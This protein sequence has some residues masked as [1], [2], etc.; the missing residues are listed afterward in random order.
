MSL[1]DRTPFLSGEQVEL[2]AVEEADLPRLRDLVNTAKI[3][4]PTD[5][6]RPKNLQ[7]E[8]DWFEGVSGD[9]DHINLVIVHDDRVIGTIGIEL[10]DPDSRTAE[11]GYFLDPDVHSQG[12]GTESAELAIEYAF[13][14]LNVRKLWARVFAFNDKSSGLL[15]KLGFEQE[16]C[17]REHK[18]ADGEY[19]DALLYGLLR[20]E[21][22]G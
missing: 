14:E 15:E 7:D 9:E 18:Y 13:D 4:I 11:I 3:R 2:Y 10:T 16:G 17:L 8:Q 20:E 12:L 19:H 5:F 21:R 6:G 1:E 22:T